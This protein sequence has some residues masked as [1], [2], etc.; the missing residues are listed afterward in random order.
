MD[1]V[2]L[3]EGESCRITRAENTHLGA[4]NELGLRGLYAKKGK[5]ESIIN[6]AAEPQ[7]WKRS[8]QRKGVAEKGE[9]WGEYGRSVGVHFSYN[10]LFPFFILHLLFHCFPQVLLEGRIACSQWYMTL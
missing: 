9:G 10:I 2:E 5:G 7:H 3:Q 6:R 8:Q 4:E 1:A